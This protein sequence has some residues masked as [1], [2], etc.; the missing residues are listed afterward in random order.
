M[1]I[2][3]FVN[4]GLIPLTHSWQAALSTFTLLLCPSSLMSMGVNPDAP[5]RIDVAILY[6]TIICVN[7]LLYAGIVAASRKMTTRSKSQ[8]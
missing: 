2:W 3:H 1:F 4:T 7:G 8:S 5:W 6:V